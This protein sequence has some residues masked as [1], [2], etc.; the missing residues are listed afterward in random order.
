MAKKKKVQAGRPKQQGAATSVESAEQSTS[1]KKPKVQKQQRAPRADAAPFEISDKTW[2]Y[3]AIGITAL[4][5]LLRFSF[6]AIKPFHHDEGVNGFFLTTLVKDGNYRYDPSNYHGP[7]LYFLTLPWA[8]IFGL[9]TI[10]VRMPMA[11][12]G[13]LT[14]VLV[15]YLR[16]YLGNLGTLFAALFVALSPGLVF[17]SRYFIHET[18]FI[19]LTFALAVAVTMFIE[20][21][22]AGRGA[23]AWMSVLIWT[24]LTP[25]AIIVGGY[26]GGDSTTAVWIWRIIFLVIDAGIT[27]FVVRSLLAWDDGRPIYFLLA[28]ACVA[29]TFA[30][31]E[32]GFITLG[33][34]IIACV[35]IFVWRRFA[36][37]QLSGK[38]L[39][40]ALVG[41]H[42]L[43]GLALLFYQV[44]TPMC[45]QESAPP[46]AKQCYWVVSD[47]FKYLYNDLLKNAWRPPEYF[48][49]Y[50]LIFVMAAALVVWLIYVTD[51]KRVQDTAY[52]EP[53][54]ITPMNF[55][56]ALGE[57][58]QP[59]IVAAVGAV[60]FLYL[61]TLFFTSF[62]T[63][64]EGFWKAF[65]AY[66]IWTKT[67]NKEHAFNGTFA[68]FKW[69]MKL[70]GP[71]MILS[72]IGLLIAFIKAKHRW[73]MFVGLWAWGLFAAYT[74]IP[75][76]T[77][78][79]A[80]SF[81]LPMCMA[82]GYAVGEMIESRNQR[83]RNA[84][85]VVT[86][87][88][89][90]L[91]CYQTYQLNF[92]RY[93]DDQMSYVYAH[94]KHGYKDMIDKIKYYAE[95]SG[96]GTQAQIEIVSPDYWPMTW[97]LN[98]YERAYFQGRLVD[99]ANPPAEM[100]VT[101]K[102]EQ[103]AQIVPKYSEQYKLAGYW[104]LRPG[105]DLC[106]LVRKDLADPDAQELS[107][108]PTLPNL[109]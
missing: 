87:A 73:G 49:F 64:K 65:E 19:F 50:T 46:A 29:L 91:L 103:D 38:R 79:L 36:A 104:P 85:W 45:F 13:T 30:T 82:A 76:K 98:K 86:A 53:L 77:P 11:I 54:E 68:Y 26:F 88:G 31:K 20:Q 95:K 109:P 67:G 14:V 63:Y 28:A 83:L 44:N 40:W 24:C 55:R 56:W 92:V 27:Y 1:A 72:V 32:T 74:I 58:I 47:G 12:F 80:I 3:C 93:D 60:F 78:W 48:V 66:N 7:T 101:K 9:N 52:E 16:R 6:L 39:V 105:V 81:I 10:P 94:T 90:A 61:F 107:K 69:C 57:G 71:I 99:I 21:W 106:V 59:A 34:M 43:A 97:D 75:Y 96:K 108:I 5:A 17:I 42:V 41:L 2:R 22:E 37:P 100:I 23:V 51:T 35:S 18:F 102:G 33:T 4:G 70:E 89:V 84:T 15:L 25:S 62:F 8:E